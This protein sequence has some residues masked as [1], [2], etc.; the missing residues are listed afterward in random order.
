MTHPPADSDALVSGQLV[1]WVNT[2]WSD[3]LGAID[4]HDIRFIAATLA[5]TRPELCVEIGCASGFSTVAIAMMLDRLGASHLH[6]FDLLDHFYAEPEQR[7]GY[8]VGER[9]GKSETQIDI[10]PGKISFDVAAT[11]GERKVDWCLIDANHKHPWPLLDTLAM[12]PLMR[13]GAYI[14]HHD[15]LMYKDT[16]DAF[17][18]CGPKVLFDQVPPRE[19][20]WFASKVDR[21][22]A[23]PMK[24][25]RIDGNIFAL[26]VPETIDSLAW[27]L[28]QGLYLPWDPLPNAFIGEETAGKIRRCL[29]ALYNPM[30]AAAFETSW[31]RYNH[32]AQPVPERSVAQRMMSR[33]RGGQSRDG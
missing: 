5:E 28:A 7:V 30:L 26:R 19:K 27:T 21:G 24:T 32:L 20:I 14:V 22:S 33:L 15:L 9:S 13:P 31:Q 12:L 25:R 23:T 4:G 17:Y 16:R 18:A 1:D 6:S 3:E 8:L 2:R 11:L 29:S 10:H